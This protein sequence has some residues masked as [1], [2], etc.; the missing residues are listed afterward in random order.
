VLYSDKCPH[1]GKETDIEPPPAG[2]CG[3]DEEVEYQQDCTRCGEPVVGR[4]KV[5]Y[6][7]QGVQ[8]G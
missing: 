6:V 2:L 1:C 7:L 8:A 4:F 5:E 3:G